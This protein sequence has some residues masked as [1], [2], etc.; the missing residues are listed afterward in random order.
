MFLM[1]TAA[2][3]SSIIVNMQKILVMKAY[4]KY[5]TMQFDLSNDVLYISESLDEIMIKLNNK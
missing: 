5:T 2:D 3:G 4:K 1:L